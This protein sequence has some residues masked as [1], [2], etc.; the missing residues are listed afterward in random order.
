MSNTAN[1]E[2]MKDEVK[3]AVRASAALPCWAIG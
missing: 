2:P 1:S 3:A